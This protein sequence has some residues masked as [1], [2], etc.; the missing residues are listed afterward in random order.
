MTNLSIL[1]ILRL[2]TAVHV[3]S[4]QHNQIITSLE[5]FISRL[6]LGFTIKTQINN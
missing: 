3:I 6:H 4:E 5:T 1:P 2:L